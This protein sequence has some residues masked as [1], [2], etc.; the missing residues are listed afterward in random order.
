MKKKKKTGRAKKTGNSYPFVIHGCKDLPA[1]PTHTHG[2]MEVGIP[3]FLMDPAA[4]GAEGNGHII[5]LAYEYF[6]KL[7]NKDKLDRILNG[8]II[9]LTYTDLRPGKSDMSPYVY[10]FRRVSTD[11]E[12]VKQAYPEY[13]GMDGWFIQIWVEGDDFALTDEY[14]KGGVWI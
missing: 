14:Y 8:E 6:S 1:F 9:K 10:C 13:E 11:F 4:F 7:E 5:N 12:A 3:E 2:L